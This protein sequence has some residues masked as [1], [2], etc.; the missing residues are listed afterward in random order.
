[1]RAAEYRAEV[2][3]QEPTEAV[4]SRVQALLDAHSLLRQRHHKGKL[5]T[6]DLRPF[7]QTVTVEPG[8]KGGHVLT[9]RLQASPEGAGRPDE[10]LK[11]LGLSLGFLHHRA[12]Q[13]VF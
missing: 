9:M 12:H 5:Q 6:Y 4:C 7:I 11:V 2:Q 8:Q 1:M 13:P 3:N 10:V